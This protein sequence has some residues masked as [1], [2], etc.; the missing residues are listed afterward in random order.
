[1]LIVDD[2]PFIL[3]VLRRILASSGVDVIE[4]LGP[5]AAL[6][7]SAGDAGDI[8]VVLTDITMPGIAGPTLVRRLTD[9]RPNIRALY[10]S[11]YGSSRLAGQGIA[12]ESCLAKPFDADEVRR[13]VVA[14][15]PPPRDAS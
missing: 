10:M 5:D 12:P 13:V 6:A 3:R 11:G 14:L 8:D 2:D 15:L 9:S 1:V 7:V 4:A